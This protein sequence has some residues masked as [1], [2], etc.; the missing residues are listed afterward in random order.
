MHVGSLGE[1]AFRRN[2]LGALPTA[3]RVLSCAQ[4]LTALRKLE[5]GKLFEFIGAGLQKVFRD[6]IGWVQHIKGDKPPA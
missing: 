4:A 2:T 6:V 3:D 1:E 5:N